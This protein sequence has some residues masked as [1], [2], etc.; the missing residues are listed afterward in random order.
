MM[1]TM[2]RVTCVLYLLALDLGVQTDDHT[3]RY[4]TKQPSSH[5]R[6]TKRFCN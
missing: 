2:D 1:E 4:I 6:P 5:L 3:G